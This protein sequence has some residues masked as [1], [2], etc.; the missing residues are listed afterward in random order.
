MVE[1][2]VSYTDAGWGQSIITFKEFM[3]RYLL[4]DPAEAQ[5]ERGIGYLAQHD[6]FSQVPSLRN[7]ISIPDYC[8]TDPPAPAQGSPLGT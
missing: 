4:R 6:L 3:S 1:M 8:Y 7:D 5:E 2:G